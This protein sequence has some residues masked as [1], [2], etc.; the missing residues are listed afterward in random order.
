ML[1]QIVERVK[2]PR[3]KGRGIRGFRCEKCRLRRLKQ[4]APFIL[5]ASGEA[6]GRGAVSRGSLRIPSLRAP[7]EGRGSIGET[8]IPE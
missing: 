3:P 1:D 5:A 6:F 2:P 8:P 7:V 4:I